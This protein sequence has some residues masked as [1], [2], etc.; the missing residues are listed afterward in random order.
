[1]HLK[2]F[3]EIDLCISYCDV[4]NYI[5]DVSDVEQVFYNVYD[6]LS[7]NGA[8]IFDVHHLPYAE[9]HLM[10]RTFSYVTDQRVYIWTC[11]STD[12]E[13]EMHHYLTFF[14]EQADGSYERFDEFHHQQTLSLS[15]YEEMLK[16]V[17]FAK[18]AFYS[19]FQLQNSNLG[20]KSERI[21]IIAEK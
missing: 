1:R 13:G 4:I 8:F 12:Q 3:Q 6:S 18:I 20:K 14:E 2:G 7:P 16:N 17:G 5:T 21:F 10:N 19:D 11:E 9:Q 15:K